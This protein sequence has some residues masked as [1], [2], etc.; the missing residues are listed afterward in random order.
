MRFKLVQK[1]SLTAERVMQIAVRDAIHMVENA[2]LRVYRHKRK[3]LLFMKIYTDPLSELLP[4]ISG[5]ALKVFLALGNRL[6]WEDTVVEITRDEIQ[7]ATNLSQ[8]T[9]REGLNE[10]E[11]LKVLTRIGPNIRRKYILNEMYVKRGK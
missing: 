8:E 7:C 2:G 4:K 11:D 5:N 6:G 3:E 9:V 10:L 1:S